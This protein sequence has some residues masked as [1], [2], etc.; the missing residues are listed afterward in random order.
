MNPYYL[1]LDKYAE[2]AREIIAEGIVLLNNEDNILPLKKQTRL[3]IFGRSVF[4][5]Y[6]SGLGSGGLVNTRYT[7]G[8]KEALEKETDLIINQQLMDH[9]S[10]WIEENPFDEGEGWG[11]VPWS[12]KEMP[13][14]DA[15]V[16]EAREQSDVAIIVIGRT[17]G[18]DQDTKNEPGSYRLTD[19]ELD[20]LDKVHKHFTQTIILL[21]TGNVIDMSWVDKYHPKGVLYVWQGGQEGGYGVA[22]ILSGRVS[23]SGRLSMSITKEVEDN[24]AH[25]NFG[26]LERNIYEEDIYVGYRYYETFDKDVIRYPFGYGLSYTDFSINDFSFDVNQKTVLAKCKVHN[27]GEAPSKE[28]VQI[29]CEAPQGRLGKPAKVLVDFGKT[30]I[31]PVN[32]SVDMEFSIPFDRFASY[33]EKTSAYV[34][35]EGRYRFYVGSHIR[36]T[37]LIGEWTSPYTVV[38]QWEEAC[39][40]VVAFDRLKAISKN[41]VLTPVKEATPLRKVN[42]DERISS[43]RPEELEY[44]GNKNNSL[45][46]VLNHKIGLDQFIQQLS[47]ED[48]ACLVRGE[49]MCSPK[50]TPGVASAFGGLTKGL[51]EK[52]IPVA[53]TAD[54]PSGIR[55]DCGTKAF[56]LPNGTLIG[57]TFN[58]RLLEE[59]FEMLGKELRRNKID[60]ILGPGLNIHRHVLNGRNFEYFSED[61]LLTGRLASAELR[62][63][64]KSQVTGTI[65]HFVANNQEAGRQTADSVVSERALREIYLK[66]FEIAV[67]EGQARSVMTSYGP[68]NG[69]WTAS[70]YDLCTQILRKEWGFKGIVM[71]DW[72]AALNFEGEPASRSNS[73][74]M[75][76]AQNDLYMCVNDAESNSGGDNTI[77]MLEEGVITRSEL[78]RNARNIL[79]FILNSLSML[80]YTNAI[81]KEELEGLNSEEDDE[82]DPSSLEYHYGEGPELIVDASVIST[83][84]GQHELFGICLAINGTYDLVVR[85]KSDLTE[86]A[87]L[88]ISLYIDN[89]NKGTISLNGTQGEWKEAVHHIGHLFGPNH[90][91]KL[92]FGVTGLKLDNLKF[93]LVEETKPFG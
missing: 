55:M 88:P 50:A 49:G 29:Y 35:E 71:T 70:N 73:A 62:G 4:H 27:I 53:C 14:S 69:I 8:I 79:G 9:Y 30:E 86:L 26:S 1:D 25:N 59:L 89:V 76:R 40:P 85:Y 31:I 61:P 66:G 11:K 90:F 84:K 17:G 2:L 39:A 93:Q 22:D 64:H 37:E 67:R 58:E 57:C 68:V 65:K 21:N 3:S 36:A 28:V 74:A 38:E 44:L 75:V 32:G 63:L 78:Q 91:I 42:L 87:Q 20:M 92:Y 6:K 80:H 46:D 18:E 45:T 83:N 33:D 82:F 15:L 72:W 77:S 5:Y 12:Q 81:S 60:T 34:L 7:I 47:D 23:P 43:Q 16:K 13:L 54:G 56:S 19:V 24:P 10:Q 48:L 41:G 51:R 52:G